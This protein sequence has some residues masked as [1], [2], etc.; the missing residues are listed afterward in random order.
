MPKFFHNRDLDFI[1]TIS[2]EVVD[3]VVEQYTTLFKMSVGESKTNLYGESLGKVYYAPV[4]LMCIVDRE[5]Q[6]IVH[7]GFGPDQTQAVEFRFN[8]LRLRREA[9]E[10]PYIKTITGVDV[11]VYAIQNLQYGY[12]EIGDILEFDGS[13]YEIGQTNEEKLIGGSPRNFADGSIQSEDPRMFLIATT[14][15]VRR[16]QIQIEDP[17]PTVT[18]VPQ[19]DSNITT[20][21]STLITF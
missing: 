17:K 13:Y 14:H 2:E 5:P 21:D 11:P 3:Y 9:Y 15:L 19:F 18:P 10:L 1:K 8:R 4:E 16:S 20:F 7:E 12:P 6:N